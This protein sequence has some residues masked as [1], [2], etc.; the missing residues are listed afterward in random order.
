MP[1][2]TL[3]YP[4]SEMARMRELYF[5]EERRSEFTLEHWDGV[6]FRHYQNPKIVCLEHYRPPDKPGLAGPSRL[7]G[8]GPKA[9]AS[10]GT[11]PTSLIAWM[12][13]TQQTV[14]PR[15]RQDILERFSGAWGRRTSSP[16]IPA[17]TQATA[18]AHR[19]VS[20]ARSPR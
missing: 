9:F 4:A 15:D 10:P 1:G 20:P 2:L 8:G 19:I 3:R 7:T 16:R 18:V 5:P 6:S 11:H 13:G 12:T 17:V 14:G